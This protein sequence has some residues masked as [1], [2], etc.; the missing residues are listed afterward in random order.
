MARSIEGCNMRTMVGVVMMVTVTPRAANS[1]AVSTS[2]V[3][4]LVVK[5]GRKRALSFLCFVAMECSE[6]RRWN[7]VCEVG[8]EELEVVMKMEGECGL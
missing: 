4:W 3:K 1:L 8:D 7:G 6:Q 5:Y 2:G